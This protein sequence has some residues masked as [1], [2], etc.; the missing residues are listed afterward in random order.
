M[1]K[2]Q[3]RVNQG[4][5]PRCGNKAAP[6]YLCYDCRLSDSLRRGLNRGEAQGVLKHERDGN[7]KNWSLTGDETKDWSWTSVVWGEGRQ[8]DKRLRPRLRGIPVEVES[9]TIDLLRASGKRGT[10][11]EEIEAAWGQLRTSGKHETVAGD[12]AALVRAQQKRER[13]AAKLRGRGQ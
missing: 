1:S 7:A 5:C 3:D 10:T 6:Y 2:Q 11:L 4:L 13:R 12:L 9:V 8:D